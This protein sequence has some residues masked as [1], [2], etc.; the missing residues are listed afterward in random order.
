MNQP[1]TDDQH[2]MA[3]ARL[4]DL[5][6]ALDGDERLHEALG[7][8]CALYTEENPTDVNSQFQDGSF[9][10]AI[11]SVSDVWSPSHVNLYRFAL[12]TFKTIEI[13]DIIQRVDTRMVD[14]IF[15]HEF[16]QKSRL[17]DFIISV[18]I[19]IIL[20]RWI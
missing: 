6:R 18:R 8:E 16:V 13:I 4:Y 2:P 15:F 5:L 20:H 12:P 19:F 10:Y 17:Q 14:I 7:P 11:S 3:A 9:T 1:P